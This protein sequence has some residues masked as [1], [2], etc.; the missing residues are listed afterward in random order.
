M[1]E[2]GFTALYRSGGVSPET[3]GQR[4]SAAEIVW[5]SPRHTRGEIPLHVPC[6]FGRAMLDVSEQSR[7]LST[8]RDGR[9]TWCQITRFHPPKRGGYRSSK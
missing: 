6:V 2:A 4:R 1:G 9:Y 8:K 3:S 7:K 5:E